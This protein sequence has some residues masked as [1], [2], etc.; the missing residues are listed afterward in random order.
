MSAVAPIADIRECG[1]IVR[2]VPKATNAP[3]Q[4]AQT[5]KPPSGGLYKIKCPI[6]VDTGLIVGV[7]L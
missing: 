6:L 7:Q 3:Q 4:L 1:R 5:E 2:F